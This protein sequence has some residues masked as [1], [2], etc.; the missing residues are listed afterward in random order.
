MVSGSGRSAGLN[1]SEAVL[2]GLLIL[3]PEIAAERLEQL[4]HAQFAGKRLAALATSLTSKLAESHRISADE[5]REE[6]VRAGHGEVV[7]AVLDKL[8]H[9]GLGGL[10]GADADR[11]A[12]VWDDAAH[13][14]LRTT[15]LSIERQ[16]AASAFARESNDVNLSRLRDIQEQDQRTLRPD[17]RD[18]TEGAMIVH[19][20]KRR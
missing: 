5:L 12:A 3:H 16:A 11:A 18:E 7:A 6:L 8:A 14:R 9:S 19:P 1:L 15:A 4:S 10:A 2:L 20:F 17:Q 13:L